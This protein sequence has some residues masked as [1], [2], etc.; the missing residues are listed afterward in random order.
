MVARLANGEIIAGHTRL[1]ACELLQREWAGATDE[2]RALWHPEAVRAA[3]GEVLVRFRDLT[4]AQAHQLALADNRL[5]EL[6]KWD[7][8]A[9]ADLL[10]ALPDPDRDLVGW[11]DL[12]L[13]RM[14]ARLRYTKSGPSGI[15]TDRFLV[16]PFSVLDGKQG[17]WLERK[18]AWM[19]LGIVSEAGREHVKNTCASIHLDVAKGHSVRVG[20]SV[21]D[22]VLAE[23][24]YRWFCPPAGAVFD[25]FAGGSVRGVVA[26]LLGRTYRGVDL[27]KSQVEAN[28]EQ[29][30]EIWGKLGK[31]KGLKQ[32]AREVV[33]FA[34]RAI[35]PVER[36]GGHWV[37]RDDLF[38]R[39]GAR[40][41]KVRT[42]S[43]LAEGAKGLVTA[44][45]RQSPQVNIVARIA[46][47]LGVP[48]RVHVP[49]GAL[50]PELLS[51]QEAGAELVQHSPGYNTVIVSRA[52]KDAAE[53][54]WTEIPFGMECQEAVEQTAAQVPAR[55][56]KD[57]RRLVVPVDSG[58]SLA[59]ILAGLES[60]GLSLPVLGVQVGADPTKRLD[61]FA[62]GWRDRCDLVQSDLDYHAAAPETQIGDLTLDPIYESKCLPF[63][64]AGDLLW[65]VGIRPSAEAGLEDVPVTEPVWKQGDAAKVRVPKRPDSDLLFSCP[66][67]FDLERY[68]DDP[69]DLSAM[70]WDAFLESY[71]EIIRRGC[72]RLRPNRFAVWVVADVRGKDGIYRGLVEETHAAFQAQGLRPYNRFVL[73]GAL[74]AAPARAAR[75]F[76]AARKVVA[77]HQEVLVYV[78]GS[79]EQAAEDCGPVV[80]TDVPS[81]EGEDG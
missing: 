4:E 60:R 14:C 47:D 42:C 32:T 24:A 48:C 70:P 73:A 36:H 28:R 77:V 66:P 41:G 15:L 38:Q 23:L 52:R 74:S 69:A 56:P 65:V 39:A 2:A 35:T 16:P 34:P 54:G 21:F 29:W 49:S 62:P 1:K 3:H 25:P 30:E 53:R 12:T 78:K 58:M 37:K 8:A 72:A 40:G 10:E 57:V 11:D 75:F 59:G 22:P 68:S 71:R 5:G 46:Q 44:G 63:L 45:S 81:A 7:D 43:A 55:F 61:E 9:L 50:T 17:Y 27:S 20:G 80:V 64:E 19:A 67:Y 76:M 33:P 79:P 51:A 31:R 18:Q 26:A 6:A 13:R